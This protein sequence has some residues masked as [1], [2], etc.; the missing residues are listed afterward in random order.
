MRAHISELDARILVLEESLT[1]ARR[2]RDNLQSRLDDY[3]YPIL[4]LPTDITAEIFIKFLPAYPERPP[5]GGLLSPALLAQICLNWRQIAFN[6]PRLWRAI[7]IYISSGKESTLDAQLNL[8]TTWLSRSKNCSLS[9]SLGVQSISPKLPHFTAA[10]ISQ[11]ERWE[12]VRLI[13]PLDDLR[14]L[15]RPFPLLRD[16]TFGPSKKYFATEDAIMAFSD[17]PRLK[18]VALGVMFNPS[19]VVLP[20]SQLTS[21]NAEEIQLDKA[22]DVLRQA[23]ALVNFSCTLWGNTIVPGAVPPLIHLDSLILHNWNWLGIQK[24]LLNALTAPALRHLA[25]S[26]YELGD[27]PLSTITAFLSRSC[28][29]L[30]S[31]HITQPIFLRTS[32]HKADYRAAF[33]SIKVIKVSRDGE[34]D[35]DGDTWG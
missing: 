23:T 31:L 19:Q 9:F 32:L 24:L 8:L 1:A 6:T 3:K 22:A 7:R 18:S 25:I 34:H 17:A 10:L 5:F 33:P 15:D 13:I 16:L 26:E 11:S 29:S 2:E 4:T 20:W 30:D 14:W 28:C 27:E 35:S 21:I 12:H